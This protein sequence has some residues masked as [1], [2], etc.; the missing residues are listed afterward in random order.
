MLGPVVGAV[1]AGLRPGEAA[2]LWLVGAAHRRLW[3][4]F[5][6]NAAGG[7]GAA[8][9]GAVGGAAPVGATGGEGGLCAGLALVCAEGWGSAAGRLAGLLSS[10]LLGPVGGGL[11]LV[12]H[13]AAEGV[14]WQLYPAYAALGVCTV[15]EGGFQQWWIRRR[16]LLSISAAGSVLSAALAVIFPMVRLPRPSGPFRVGRRN[17]LWED[18]SRPAFCVPVPEGHQPHRRCLVDVWYPRERGE[19]Q[20]RWVSFMQEKFGEKIVMSFG[21]PGFLGS[22]LG[23]V[24]SSS[25]RDAAPLRGQRFPVLLFS[26]GLYSTR[27]AH[28]A[29][30]EE[31]VSHGF[32][33]AAMDH[34]YDAISVTFP[35]GSEI[36]YMVEYP[37]VNFKGFHAYRSD[38]L[39]LRTGDVLF[40][41][42]RLHELQ[43]AGE[44]AD[45][46]AAALDLAPGVSALGHSFGGCT[47]IRAA[48]R[49]ARIK[50][51]LA[52][53]AWLWPMGGQR[54]AEGLS[55][56]VVLLESETFLDDRDIFTAFNPVLTKTFTAAS[57]HCRQVVVKGAGHY[58]YTDMCWVSPIFLRKFGLISLTQREIR[59][60]HATMAEIA[61]YFLRTGRLDEPLLGR[62]GLDVEC[63]HPETA[64]RP[65]NHPL[66]QKQKQAYWDALRRLRTGDITEVVPPREDDV[67]FTHQLQALVQAFPEPDVRRHL[68]AAGWQGAAP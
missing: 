63:F 45:P 39:E 43:A 36:D 64:R 53:D 61:H 11:V 4:R 17:Y 40:V 8:G 51:V 6:G 2:L 5:G 15:I 56:P 55:V 37:E 35:D 42:D 23:L 21:F 47:A 13:A 58:E 48:Q 25:V 38:N 67:D 10:A 49:D 59:L 29:L 3:Q 54:A 32:V 44:E 12:W 16:L 1:A 57:P 33:V 9:G 46:L 31:I 22:H 66:S 34:P 52:L 60:L 7:G 19:C 20:G 26:H 28:T 14:R 50:R 62:C 27:Q 24:R 41:L 65:E 68:L 18:H 30:I